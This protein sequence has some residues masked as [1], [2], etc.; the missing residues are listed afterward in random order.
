V[1]AIRSVAVVAACCA[2]VSAGA[3]QNV[4]VGL[5]SCNVS[6]QVE[7]DT[8][9][10]TA[11]APSRQV[12]CAFTAKNG[13]EE[14]YMGE[15]QVANPTIGGQRT[16]LWSVKA[17]SATPVP[18]GFL[19]QTYAADPKTPAGQVPDIIGQVNSSVILQSMTEK[20]E[21]SASAGEKAPPVGFAVL[22]LELKLK[23]TSG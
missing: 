11:V 9:H 6:G 23:S 12:Q 1:Q 2:W 15:V 22:G 20:K 18:P 17:P 5:L 10:V 14:T 7:A 4:E 16:L 3:Q 8:G 19:Q 13:A 21:G